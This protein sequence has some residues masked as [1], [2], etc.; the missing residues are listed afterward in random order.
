MQIQNVEEAGYVY[1]RVKCGR[2]RKSFDFERIPAIKKLAPDGSV[3]LK[4]L[5][6]TSAAPVN[7]PPYITVTLV[8]GVTVQLAVEPSGRP[9]EQRAPRND[10]SA[11]C[12][13]LVIGMRKH[14][15]VGDKF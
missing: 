13:G 10:G 11:Q 6:V 9:K 12:S 2:R 4:P 14:A 15:C 3:L 5:P 7:H 8:E 1:R